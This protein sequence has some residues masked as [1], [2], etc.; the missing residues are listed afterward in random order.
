[1]SE[2]ALKGRE[3]KTTVSRPLP[4]DREERPIPDECRPSWCRPRARH[5]RSI[6]QSLLIVRAC[7]V[8]HPDIMTSR[9]PTASRRE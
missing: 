2:A 8:A 6:A 3:Q 1:V 7:F 4:D 9:R 5:L